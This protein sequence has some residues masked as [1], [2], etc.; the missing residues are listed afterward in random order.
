MQLDLFEINKPIKK[1]RLVLM[2]VYKYPGDNT[3]TTTEMCIYVG[4]NQ[5]LWFGRDQE[6]ESIFGCAEHG[7]PMHGLEYAPELV[8]GVSARPNPKYGFKE[9][10]WYFRDQR[11]NTIV[12]SGKALRASLMLSEAKKLTSQITGL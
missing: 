10:R 4:K 5:T 7:T 1:E 12:M 3:N 6:E 9:P 8:F 2:G 11:T